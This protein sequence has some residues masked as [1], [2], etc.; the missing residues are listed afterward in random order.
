M[1]SAPLP[2]SYVEAHA[3]DGAVI[4]HDERDRITP[5]AITPRDV[6]VIRAVA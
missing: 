4:Q 3:Y 6:A 1:T 2:R 5:C